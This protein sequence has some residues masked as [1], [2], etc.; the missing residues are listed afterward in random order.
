[1]IRPTGRPVV[2][3]H[4]AIISKGALHT[5]YSEVLRNP[6]YFGI[7]S[8]DQGAEGVA[9][10]ERRLPLGPLVFLMGQ[11]AAGMESA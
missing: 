1:M 2:P 7:R 4:R 10:A 9:I 5:S 11:E 8:T 3:Y 6:E